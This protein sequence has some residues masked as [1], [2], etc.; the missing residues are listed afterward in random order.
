MSM[1][2]Q[3]VGSIAVLAGFALSQWGV[4]NQKST[5][6]LLVNALGSL[7]LAADAVIERQWGF[8]LLEGSWSVISIISF[9]N[10]RIRYG[11][12]EPNDD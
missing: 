5:T 6:Y 4:L 1:V 3:I 11:I 9:V 10:S 2:V 8:L 7:L 12:H